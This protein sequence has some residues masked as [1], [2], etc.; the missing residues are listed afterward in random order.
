MKYSKSIFVKKNS[1]IL[2]K[3]LRWVKR[4]HKWLAFVKIPFLKS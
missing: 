3:G 4:E 2:K 1:S